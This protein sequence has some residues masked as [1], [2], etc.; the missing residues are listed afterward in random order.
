MKR[1]GKLSHPYSKEIDKRCVMDS[2]H[3]VLQVIEGTEERCV[4]A[5]IVRVMGS[6]YRKEGTVALFLESG[7]QVGMLTAGCLEEDLA[8]RAQEMYGTEVSK[9]I[10]YDLSAEAESDWGRGPG[11]NGEIHVVL[12]PVDDQ[13][14]QSLKDIKRALEHGKSLSVTKVVEGQTFIHCYH[15]KPRLVLFGAGPDAI[16]VSKLAATTGFN[17]IVTDWRPFF[18]SI[19]CFPEADERWVGVPQ[20]VVPQLNLRRDDCV[21]IMT[22]D[23]RRDR[24]ILSLLRDTELLYLGVLGSRARTVRLVD[25]ES[26]LTTIHSP[27]GLPI[28]AEGPQEIAVSIVADL[29]LYVRRKRHAGL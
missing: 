19:D 14:R 15:P 24:E 17:V 12:E 11:C 26:L 3:A 18:C 10:T 27:V 7:R 25:E 1:F 29:I 5:T 20:E 28:G 16:P 22:H 23:F 6:S 2:I 21:V 9:L 4:L 13:R 8:L